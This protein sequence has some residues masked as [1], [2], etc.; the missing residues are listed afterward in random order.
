MVNSIRREI[1]Y[2][3]FDGVWKM[4]ITNDNNIIVIKDDECR[5]YSLPSTPT[6][7]EHDC[8]YVTLTFEDGSFYQC[9]FEVNSFFVGDKFD[10]DEEHVES[11]ANHE[12]VKD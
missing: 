1:E 8:E 5:E 10:S 4:L 12:F 2:T 3:G 9:K 6:S 11:F 7:I